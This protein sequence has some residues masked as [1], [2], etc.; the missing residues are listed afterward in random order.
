VEKVVAH[1]LNHCYR[2]LQVNKRNDLAG[3]A[4]KD[5]GFCNA[6]VLILVPFKK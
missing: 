6:K 2:S 4:V 3:E 5:R 1:V